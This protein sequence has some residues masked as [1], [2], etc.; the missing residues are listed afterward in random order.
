MALE[1]ILI[2]VAVL[3][4]AAKIFGEIA[5]RFGIAS[6]VGELVGGI[7][8]GPLLG[9]VAVGWFLTDFITI[10]VI[11]LLFMAGLEVRFEDIKMHTYSA[12]ILAFAAGIM[13]FFLGFLVGMVFFQDIIISLAIG[14]ALSTTSDGTLFLFLMKSG[15]FKTRVGRLITAITIADDIV[16]ILLLSFFSVFIKSR[17]FPL[18][19]VFQLFLVSIGFYFLVF[20][21]GSRIMN[22]ILNFVG[23]FV[24]ETILFTVPVAFAFLLAYATD[25]LGLSIATGAFLTGMAIA[26]SHYSGS[27]IVPKVAVVGRGFLIPLF[28]AIVGASLIFADFNIMLVIFI[29]LAAVFGKI[30]GIWLL[31][32]FFGLDSTKKTLTCI[33]MVPRGN[34]NIAILQIVLLMGAITF[35]VYTSVV[36]AIVATILLTPILLKVFCRKK[37]NIV[38]YGKHEGF[39]FKRP[40]KLRLL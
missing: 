6:L 32:G 29:L 31:Y 23:R 39:L 25:N 1:S 14:V 15:E 18:D 27:V 2:S 5:E 9:L 36:F 33:M 38:E 3:L 4:L 30:I 22:V 40:K 28:Y 11:F 16:G 17:I 21:A 20:T 19:T 12:S 34:E 7:I 10:P 37:K 8:V 24:D 35:K 13:S 26:N